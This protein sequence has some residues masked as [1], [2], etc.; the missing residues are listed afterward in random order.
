MGTDVIP[1]A[2]TLPALPLYVPG[3]ISIA[4]HH[5]LNVIART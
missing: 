4:K 2:V 1:A 3:Q 5:K